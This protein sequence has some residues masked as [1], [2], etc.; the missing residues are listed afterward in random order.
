MEKK[1]ESTKKILENLR[2]DA[3]FTLFNFCYFA[4]RVPAALSRIAFVKIW[5][6]YP[7]ILIYY[8]DKT[9]PKQIYG[10][11]LEKFEVD[12]FYKKCQKEFKQK[13]GSA[14]PDYLL[15]DQILK[16]IG[17]Q[18]KKFFQFL[19]KNS[20]HI[21]LSQ[22]HGNKLY[23]K[24]YDVIHWKLKEASNKPVVILLGEAH[25][26]CM[27]QNLIVFEIIKATGRFH[28]LFVELGSKDL[29]TY[30]ENKRKDVH[31]GRSSFN[32]L[33]HLSRSYGITVTPVENNLL[34]RY[35]FIATSKIGIFLRDMFM[36]KNMLAPLADSPLGK[37]NLF[38]CGADHIP[39]L[40]RRLQENSE[41]YVFSL[42]F[43]DFDILSE[44]EWKRPKDL[45]FEEPSIEIH[46]NVLNAK[47]AHMIKH[48]AGLSELPIE[49]ISED[50]FKEI[51][52]KDKKT[53]FIETN[54]TPNLLVENSFML[55]SDISSLRER[56]QTSGH[57]PTICEIKTDLQ[58]YFAILVI[59]NRL[60]LKDYLKDRCSELASL[61]T[62]VDIKEW[63]V[64]V[65][66]GLR[67]Q[68]SNGLWL[69]GE[70]TPVIMKLADMAKKLESL[71]SS[72]E[73]GLR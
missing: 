21:K 53:R 37:I 31:F 44:N 68:V 17:E 72:N 16:E 15:S 36:T 38:L 66:H 57:K 60:F 59:E 7:K 51:E 71:D 27:L 63:L 52:E 62:Q 54:A 19:K 30:L 13:E 22:A 24:Y 40:T 70:V 9:N 56:E 43:R 5:A 41:F 14:D 55:F 8:R 39:G 42:D 32:Y 4:N 58:K 61:S 46:A 34:R 3:Q 12:E 23:E 45:G 47:M 35:R 25:E 50:E 18:N 48:G 49:T 2:V 28:N 29:D 1:T 69:E 33:C 10:V 73:L 20:D 26:C 65:I 6:Y 11:E 64:E 67:G